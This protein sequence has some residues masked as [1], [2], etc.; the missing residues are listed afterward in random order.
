MN[1]DPHVRLVLLETRDGLAVAAVTGALDIHT[2]QRLGEEAITVLTAHPHLV[3]DLSQVTFC[4]SSG[5]NTLIRLRTPRRRG[6][7]QPRPGR[8]TR[9]DDAT[10]V[11]HRYGHRL[12]P[13]CRPRPGAG[14]SCRPP[15]PRPLTVRRSRSSATSA[16]L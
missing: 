4:D 16:R 6:R 11:R 13:P 8:R 12:H 2:A 7:W 15:S 1:S 10:A 3:L 14:R 5:L 9:P